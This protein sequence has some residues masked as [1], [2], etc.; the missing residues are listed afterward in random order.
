MIGSMAAIK[1][2]R[3]QS[4]S[5]DLAKELKLQRKDLEPLSNRTGLESMFDR[6]EGLV[7]DRFGNSP[8]KLSSAYSIVRLV[9]LSNIRMQL[10]SCLSLGGSQPSDSGLCPFETNRN[11]ASN[12]LEK[13][14]FS[15]LQKR[16]MLVKRY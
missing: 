4:G 6:V 5:Y 16:G 10:V 3:G 9:M 1:S 12:S 8:S 13:R 7:N 15:L 2:D 14:T 11:T